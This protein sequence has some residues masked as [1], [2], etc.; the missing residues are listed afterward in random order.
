MP[1]RPSYID[2]ALNYAAQF[3]SMLTTPEIIRNT[4]CVCLS[5]CLSHR[6]MRE[7][8]LINC[9]R[10]SVPPS[11]RRHRRRASKL[12]APAYCGAPARPPFAPPVERWLRRP[13]PR[14]TVTWPSHVMTSSLHVAAAVTL[15]VATHTHTH[16]QRWPQPQQ[17]FSL[18]EEVC[19]VLL[20]R[21]SSPKCT[22]L[23]HSLHFANKNVAEIIQY[24]LRKRACTGRPISFLI[25]R[26]ITG[27]WGRVLLDLGSR[28]PLALCSWRQRKLPSIHA[29]VVNFSVAIFL[30]VGKIV[31]EMTRK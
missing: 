6:R 13:E 16:S 14:A 4:E 28:I 12:P 30:R 20:R 3:A 23:L 31:Y 22:F 17:D 24:Y 2:I 11:L 25:T 5:V 18:R 8:R 21:R 9:F 29:A 19:P 26:L 10:Q 15:W 7:W 27:L 1:V